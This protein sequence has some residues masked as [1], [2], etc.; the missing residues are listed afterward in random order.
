MIDRE[1]IDIIIRNNGGNNWRKPDL[2]KK[3]TLELLPKEVKLL[4]FPPEDTEN[5]N[6]FIYALGLSKN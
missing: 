5:Y 2:Y 1:N 4:E 3:H 6:C